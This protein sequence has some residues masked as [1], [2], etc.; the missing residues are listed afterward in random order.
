MSAQPNTFTDSLA[1]RGDQTARGTIGNPYAQLNQ[2]GIASVLEYLYKGANLVDVAETTNVSVTV[3][4]T[5]LDNEGHWPRVEEATVLS[6]EGYLAM[7]Q[8]L[9]KTAK[10]P[11]ELAKAKSL[12]EHSRWLAGKINKPVYGTT[13][14]AAAGTTVSF[15]LNIGGQHATLV[16]SPQQNHLEVDAQDLYLPPIVMALPGAAEPE[17]GPFNDMP[18]P[19]ELEF[20]QLWAG[21]AE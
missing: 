18:D 2:I 6:A 20:E 9:M 10:N 3:L 5:W 13:E 12:L 8:R 11:F 17:I 7:G 19:R 21:T 4:R 16:A 15:T 14:V 1:V